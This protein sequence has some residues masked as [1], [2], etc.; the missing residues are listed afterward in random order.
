[1]PVRRGAVQGRGRADQCPHL[2]LPQLPEGD[3]IAFLC[4]RAVPAN[5]EGE[6]ARYASS[7]ALDRVFCKSCG[8]RLFSWRRNG[9]AAGVALATFDDRNA[10][11]PTDH[12]WFAEKM[13][14]VKLDDGLP[15]YQ[16]TVPA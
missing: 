15:Q 16:G 6:T 9:T 5:R 10:F 12:I 1:M 3:G 8:T 13:D 2:P 11:A 7:E 4:P 14:W